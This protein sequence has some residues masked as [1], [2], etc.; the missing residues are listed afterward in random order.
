MPLPSSPG[1][2]AFRIHGDNVVECERTLEL[3]HQAL[4]SLHPSLAGPFGSPVC[5]A[6][7][8]DIAGRAAMHFTFLP[9]YGG[10]RWQ[11]D[12]LEALRCRG[13]VL[14]EA[15][16]AIVTKV[17]N[18]VEE[19]LF[20]IEYCG[21]LPAGNQAW[22]RNGRALSF[23]AAGV[24]YLY[25]A[26]LG[27]FELDDSRKRKAE[28]LPNPAVPFSYLVT[29]RSFKSMAVPV[30]IPSPGASAG[31]VRKYAPAYGEQDVLG[32]VRAYVM[33]TSRA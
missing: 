26:E 25:I 15:A 13:G 1:P 8:I 31:T 21:A 5:P 28:R 16:D 9:G 22:Q 11:S 17:E 23:A 20:A 14:R 4:A 30:Y 18:G 32:L 6:Y 3:V 27:G 10:T 29:C 2:I 7:R 19:M 12:I 24:P 33:G